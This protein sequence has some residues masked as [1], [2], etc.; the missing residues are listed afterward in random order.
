MTLQPPHRPC[1][2]TSLHQLKLQHAII[3]SCRSLYWKESMSTVTE[4]LGDVE[5]EVGEDGEAALAVWS[6]VQCGFWVDSCHRACRCCRDGATVA[7]APP[8][9]PHH[10]QPP[11]KMCLRRP[12]R[13]WGG[14]RLTSC[15][16]S[17]VGGSGER[18]ARQSCVS[19]SA[20]Q[21]RSRVQPIQTNCRCHPAGFTD[22]WERLLFKGRDLLAASK[23]ADHGVVAGVTVTVVRRALFAD[24]WEVRGR[25]TG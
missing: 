21:Q 15:C 19:C 4:E 22:E 25:R 3:F 11:C 5:I 8:T 6:A 18:Q 13:S 1:L 10:Q 17:K 14:R 20:G 9:P 16:G 2:P 24:G 7:S 23:L 12:P